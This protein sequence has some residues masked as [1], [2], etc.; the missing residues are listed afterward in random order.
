MALTSTPGTAFGTSCGALAERDKPPLSRM[1]LWSPAG[2]GSSHDRLPKAPFLGA[3]VRNPPGKECSLQNRF[4]HCL[5]VPLVDAFRR[6]LQPSTG[7]FA[8]FSFGGMVHRAVVFAESQ[9]AR[10]R[11]SACC[12]ADASQAPWASSA[13]ARVD[14]ERPRAASK[15]PSDSRRELRGRCRGA[16]G[17]LPALRC[18]PRRGTAVSG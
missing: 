8:A 3:S 13:G 5:Q 15:W 4:L 17:A 9:P 6:C 2:G 1:Q 12:P 16:R 14:V 10:R 18:T 11:Q 7:H